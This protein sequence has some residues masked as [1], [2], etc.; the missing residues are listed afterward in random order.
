MRQVAIAF[1]TTGND[2]KKGHCFREM[3]AV[4]QLE[5]G[6]CSRVV[7]LSFKTPDDP[8]RKPFAEQFPE[9]DALIG[10]ATIVVHNAGIWKKFL[11]PELA[12]VKDRKARRL[13]TQVFDVNAWA[14]RSFPKQRRSLE[15]IA[16]KTNIKIEGQQSGLRLNAERL[17]LIAAVAMKQR[18]EPSIPSDHGVRPDTPVRRLARRLRF[19]WLGLRGRA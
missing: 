17:R 16:R 13:L 15:I 5:D 6:T 14:Q 18:T 12:T 7:Q 2:P 11:R 10:D 4:E 19:C 8:E 1:T 3:V 9:L